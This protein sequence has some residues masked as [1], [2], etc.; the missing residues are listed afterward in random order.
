MVNNVVGWGNWISVSKLSPL[1]FI[2][3]F[4]HLFRYRDT[5][6]VNSLKESN[7][8]DVADVSKIDPISL[9]RASISESSAIWVLQI[10]SLEIVCSFHFHYSNFHWRAYEQCNAC[11][12]RSLIFCSGSFHYHNLT[13]LASLIECSWTARFECDLT[14]FTYFKLSNNARAQT[15]IRV[16]SN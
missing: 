4:R 11:T 7:L 14:S 12:I 5:K 1:N 6:K 2:R 3:N 13:V 8:S 9:W 15:P 16:F 10:L